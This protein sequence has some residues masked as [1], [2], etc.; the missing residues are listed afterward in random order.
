MIFCNININ[1]EN[2]TALFQPARDRTMKIINTLN[3][4]LIVEANTSRRFFNFLNNG[5]VTFDGYIP[6]IV[7]KFVYRFSFIFRNAFNWEKMS[8]FD[9]Q[10]MAG[11]DIVYDFCEFAK[12]ENYKIFFLGG[13]TESNANAVK[14]IKAK[15]NIPIEGF[16]PPFENYPFSDDFNKC[17]LDRVEQ[18]KPEILFLGFGAPKQEY[19]I[20]DNKAILAEIGVKY[21][22]AS[23]GTFD[24]VSNT[25]KRAPVF[26]QKIGLEG[27]YR[28]FQEPNRIRYKRLIDSFKFFKYIWHR[29][30]FE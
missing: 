3:A 17:C 19:W 28:F 29:P 30:D 13:K 10:K 20:D 15:Y 26:I 6:Y 24:F 12:R 4:A 23:G 16:S 5:Y 8:K 21:A 18:F 22:I 9:F 14:V 27:L 2:K 7:A 1:L 25:I 11:S